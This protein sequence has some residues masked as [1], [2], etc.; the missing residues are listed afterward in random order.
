MEKKKKIKV[1]CVPSDSGG[2]GLHRSVGPHL[3]LDERHGKDFDVTIDHKPNWADLKW[4]S[5]FDIVNFHKGVYGDMDAF[6]TALEFCKANNIVTVMDIDDYWEVGQNHPL[7]EINKRS[8]SVEITK[9]NLCKA[10]YVTTTT[11]IFADKIKHFNENVKV[12]VNA[13]D[14]EYMSELCA[15]KKPSDRIR[16]GFVMGSSH[17][18]DM[19]LIR[20]LS[21]Q[22]PKSVLDKIQFNLCG[23]DQR[24]TMHVFGP[25]GEY[26]TRKILPSENVW[27]RFEASI[28]DNYRIVSPEYKDFLLNTGKPY[29]DYP[30]ASQEPYKRC[31]TKRVQNYEYMKQYN[32]IDVLM[33][34]LQSKEFNKY[35]SEL[36]F[37]EAGMMGAGVI[38][39]NY[40]PYTIGSTMFFGKGG[41]VNTEG[42]CVLVDNNKAHKE[43]AKYIKKLVEN[44]EYITMLQNNMRKHVYENY[45]INKITDE[46]AAWYK[47]IVKR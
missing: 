26:T 17:E 45:D 33:V 46:R 9:V 22:L 42:N 11:S 13:L 30:L 31:W 27:Y 23:F 7:Y 39:S 1:L 14:P 34:P 37:V 40:G 36:K 5:Q 24:G 3:K 44:P 21:N 2:V 47:E 19:E 32:N 8:N 41:S 18:H 20:G 12:F 6:N 10:D 15:E 16:F 35:K 38:A 43:W 28:T 4:L 29:E 25:N